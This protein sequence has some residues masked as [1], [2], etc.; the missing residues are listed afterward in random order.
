[1]F[2][3][4]WLVKREHNWLLWSNCS[5]STARSLPILFT[6]TKEE[7]GKQVKKEEERRCWEGG[8]T[9][10][11]VIAFPTEKKIRVQQQDLAT[12]NEK[13]QLPF[14]MALL[15]ELLLLLNFPPKLAFLE[16]LGICVSKSRKMSR[17][18]KAKMSEMKSHKK[19]IFPTQFAK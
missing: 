4:C 1:M 19:A 8:T 16:S 5:S 18:Q 11:A 10:L 12:I 17:K 13:E 7:E 6:E 14:L 3:S 9:K 2:A 15:M